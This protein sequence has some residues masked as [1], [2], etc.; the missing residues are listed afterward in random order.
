MKFHAR[1]NLRDVIL[2]AVLIGFSSAVLGA[3]LVD[4]WLGL[5]IGW[6]V[7]IPFMC[8]LYFVVDDE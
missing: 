1:M 8:G 5:L 2:S 7:T 6:L 4:G 3:A